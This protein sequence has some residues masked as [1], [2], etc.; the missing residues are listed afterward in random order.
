[1]FHVALVLNH[2]VP[3]DTGKL[4]RLHEYS[5]CRPSYMYEG[6]VDACGAAQGDARLRFATSHDDD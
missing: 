4:Q 3:M 5:S 1:V 6:A 2:N